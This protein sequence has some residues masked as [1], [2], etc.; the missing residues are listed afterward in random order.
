MFLLVPRFTFT[1][2]VVVICTVTF[3]APQVL[4]DGKKKKRIERETV[5]CL[6]A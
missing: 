5:P 6:E 1:S 2:G 3:K 4:A